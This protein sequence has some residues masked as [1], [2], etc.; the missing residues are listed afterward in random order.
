[1]TTDELILRTLHNTT[2]TEELRD[3]EIEILASIIT[4]QR[5]K[6]GEVIV[7]PGVNPL[8][9]SL[10]I[11]A[12][13]EAE[14]NAVVDGEPMTLP[15]SKPGDLASIIGFVGGKTTTINAR[16]EVKQDGAVLLLDRARFESLLHS[17]PA[18]VYYV[19]RGLVRYMHGVARRKTAESAE[20]NNYF[21]RVHGRY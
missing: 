6:A 14:I 2:L 8:R 11:L 5:Y 3:S 18:I 19:M 20:M 12:E 15:L 13:G 1:M 7:E 16:V 17:H 10:M 21:Y 4:V 9:E